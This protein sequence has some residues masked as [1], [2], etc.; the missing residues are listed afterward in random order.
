MNASSSI[1]L[2]CEEK[3]LHDFHKYISESMQLPRES[4]QKIIRT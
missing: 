1:Y 3:H 2:D 4:L